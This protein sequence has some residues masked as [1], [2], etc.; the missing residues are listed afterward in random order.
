M[1]APDAAGEHW[2][3]S[4]SSYVYHTTQPSVSLPLLCCCLCTAVRPFAVSDPP[5]HLQESLTNFGINSAALAILSFL[6]YRDL[7]A[8]KKATSVTSREEELGRLLVSGCSTQSQRGYA[9]PG[10]AVQKQLAHIP[11]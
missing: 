3:C 1:C 10:L 7:Q 11:V 5:L 6:V 4:H 2:T 8:Q 9:Q